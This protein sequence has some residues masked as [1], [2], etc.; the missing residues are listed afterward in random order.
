MTSNIC[1][2]V[3]YVDACAVLGIF[4]VKQYIDIIQLLMI[5]RM[6]VHE[7]QSRGYGF[8]LFV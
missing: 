6:F 2:N 8:L 4:V 3:R 7:T 5:G 1:K